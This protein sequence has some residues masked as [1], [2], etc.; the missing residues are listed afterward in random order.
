[1]KAVSDKVIIQYFRGTP[2]QFD[3]AAASFRRHQDRCPST[4]PQ[5]PRNHCAATQRPCPRSGPAAASKRSR[6]N[7]LGGRGTS[8]TGRSALF[9]RLQRFFDDC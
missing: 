9:G 1:M 5:R 2:N 8:R 7:G 6:P 4:T 3:G